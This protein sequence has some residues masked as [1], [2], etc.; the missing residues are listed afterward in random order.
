MHLNEVIQGC[1][2]GNSSSQ[3]ELFDRLSGKMM[4]VC[5]RYSRDRMEAEDLLQES[6]I[7]IYLN[8]SSFKSDGHIEMWVR[9]IVI[10]TSIKRYNKLSYQNESPSSDM[11]PDVEVGM[12]AYDSMVYDELLSMINELPDGYRLVFNLYA[13]EG[14]SHKEIAELLKIKEGTSRSQLVKARMALQDKFKK[15]QKLVI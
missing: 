3:K 13:I 2:A 4:A 15:S 12:N 5:L 8:L 1:L 11:M 6:F 14:Y 9:R 7:K 10:N